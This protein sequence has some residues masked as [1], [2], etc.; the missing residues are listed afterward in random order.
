METK[1]E[2]MRV[3][4]SPSFPIFDMG[5]FYSRLG[6]GFSPGYLETVGLGHGSIH[7]LALVNI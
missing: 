4:I 3:A 7:N 5:R 2:K 1:V 6:A